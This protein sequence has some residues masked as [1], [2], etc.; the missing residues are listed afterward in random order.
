MNK[1]WA[2]YGQLG[3]KVSSK[4]CEDFHI[5]SN[6]HEFWIEELQK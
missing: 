6:F 5:A 3:T 4:S 2:M 1:N